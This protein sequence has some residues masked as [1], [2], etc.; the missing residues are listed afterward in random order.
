MPLFNKGIFF[1]LVPAWCVY[2]FKASPPKS[3]WWSRPSRQTL[4]ANSFFFPAATCRRA[5]LALANH[6]RRSEPFVYSRKILPFFLDQEPKR[7]NPF[8]FSASHCG[9]WDWMG[10]KRLH[11][12]VC[13]KR[14]TFFP[15]CIPISLLLVCSMIVRPFFDCSSVKTSFFRRMVE[16][17][18]NKGRTNPSKN[19]AQS[20]K[21]GQ[22][23][24]K[25]VKFFTG[26]EGSK[27]S[28]Y[29]RITNPK[30]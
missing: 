14:K 17:D 26:L 23:L 21:I 15:P 9:Q 3:F 22:R 27:I 2:H 24:S 16:H 19:C 12:S 5:I 10:Y 25:P 30:L 18:S 28:F 1:G 11:L 29:I 20:V 13:K 6:R 7:Y 4:I 8:Y